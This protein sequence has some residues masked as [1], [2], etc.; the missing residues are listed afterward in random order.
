MIIITLKLKD[1]NKPFE[2]YPKAVER[3]MGNKP[4][5]RRCGGL[6]KKNG[7]YKRSYSVHREIYFFQVQRIL[8]K[9]C[10][11]SH[12]LLPCNLI[13]YSIIGAIER[14]KVLRK[15]GEKAVIERIAE[16][17]DV[18]PRTVS[19][20]CRRFSRQTR[21]IIDWVS[22]HLAAHFSEINWLKGALLEGRDRV[23]W[24]LKLLDLF[25]E[26]F[27]PEF[28]HGSLSLLNFLAYEFLI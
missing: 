15:Y 10:G 11:K 13:P 7:T 8:C 14:E 27:F 5:C 16:E 19:G 26:Y 23:F 2:D 9:Q 20:W 28:P 3:W 1:V 4:F 17:I 25:R 12:A 6:F 24:V 21:E 22:K 18:A